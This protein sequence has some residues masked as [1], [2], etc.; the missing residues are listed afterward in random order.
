MMK[1]FIACLFMLSVCAVSSLHAQTSGSTS[2]ATGSDSSSSDSGGQSE[3]SNNTHFW[4]I[5]LPGG[6]YVVSLESI[7][8]VSMHEY[9]LD[10][11]LVVNE[12]VIDTTG[13]SLVR[14]YHIA[15]VTEAMSDNPVKNAASRVTDLAKDAAKRTNSKLQD[16]V[17]KSYP[18]T[19]H[20]GMVEYRVD[21]LSALKAIFKS[22]DNAW[23]T[24]RG[25][26]VTTDSS[27]GSSSDSGSK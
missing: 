6:N 15:P 4:K 13:R 27:N 10:Q 25:K 16:M 8:S 22:V 2:S 24:G 26:T 11:N 3:T 9:L 14:F 5:S 20:A 7:T 21:S 18:T 17:Q 12:V 19:T 23:E 1:K